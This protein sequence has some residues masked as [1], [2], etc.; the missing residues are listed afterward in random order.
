MCG[1]CGI[2]GQQAEE[3]V[4]AMNQAIHHRGPD[5]EGYF[6][7]ENIS[8]ASKRL[9]IIDLQTGSQ[10]VYNE[11]K[12]IVVVFNGEIYNFQSIREELC[13]KG[14]HFTSKGDTEVIAH[15]YEEYNTDCLQKF[16]GDFAFVLHDI[17]NNIT[18]IA[19][20]RLGIRPLYYT[21]IDN[22]IIFAS[23]LKAIL[24]GNMLKKKIN[25]QAIDKYLTLRYCWGTDTFF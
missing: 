21:M 24:A 25:C 13:R 9:S 4:K 1:I 20:D 3:T 2:I 12:S 16:N 19:R 23:E 10:P 5:E 8:L 7:N 18:F 22:K 17:A 6:F 11:D 14:H 15:A